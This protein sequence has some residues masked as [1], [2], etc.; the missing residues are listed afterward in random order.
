VRGTGWPAVRDPTAYQNGVVSILVG[1]G[2]CAIFDGEE[3][4]AKRTNEFTERYRHQ[5]LGSLHPPR[6]RIYRGA[7]YPAAF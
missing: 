1:K 2:Y 4:T 3:I 5:L 6:E 7:C